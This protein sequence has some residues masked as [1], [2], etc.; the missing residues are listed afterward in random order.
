MMKKLVLVAHERLLRHPR[1][2]AK[3]IQISLISAQQ[4]PRKLVLQLPQMLNASAGVQGVR[5]KNV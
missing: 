4:K 5:T 2:N 3:K 1:I